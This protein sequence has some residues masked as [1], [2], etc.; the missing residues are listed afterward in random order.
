MKILIVDDEP[1]ARD[2]VRALMADQPDFEVIGEAADGDA[3][4]AFLSWLL[5][6]M[7]CGAVGGTIRQNV[8]FVLIAGPAVLT[9]RP[10]AHSAVRLAGGI[11]LAF[12][13]ASVRGGDLDGHAA[14]LAA[15][16]VLA[17]VGAHRDAEQLVA[18]AHADVRRFVRDDSR[19]SR[20]PL[21]R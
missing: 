21:V 18:E 2:R 9:L 14:H 17:D 20:L 8:W 7:L 12:G 5:L 3:W 16:R 13:V 19:S 10:R 11:C 15:A 4:R 1:L 6:G